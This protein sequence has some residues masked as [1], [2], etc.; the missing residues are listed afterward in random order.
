[1]RQ[2][3]L[4]CPPVRIARRPRRPA[5]LRQLLGGRTGEKRGKVDVHELADLEC[6]LAQ[7][8]DTQQPLI[9]VWTREGTDQDPPQLEH[10]EEERGQPLGGAGGEGGMVG[11]GV[12]GGR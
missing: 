2:A 12:R 6:G 8:T 1:M 5:L 10:S 4:V 7:P 11:E 9:A 3:F